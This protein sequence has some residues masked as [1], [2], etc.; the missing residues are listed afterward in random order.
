V[1]KDLCVV[2]TCRPARGNASKAHCR[3][4]KTMLVEKNIDGADDVV[5]D[6]LYED[7]E[8]TELNALQVSMD[9]LG[10]E[11]QLTVYSPL[12]TMQ[13]LC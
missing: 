3:I 7:P 13:A 1:V 6:G 11:T 10:H 12:A 5:Q 2:P 9:L 4:A 8:H